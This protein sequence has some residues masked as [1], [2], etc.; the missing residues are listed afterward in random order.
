MDKRW[1][2][3]PERRVVRSHPGTIELAIR[4]DRRHQHPVE[5][6]QQPEDES[7]ER[8]I[9]V[10]P[11]AP[12]CPFDHSSVHL[13]STDVEKLHHHN[14]EQEREHGERNGCALTQQTGTD[15]NLI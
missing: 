8:N 15:A 3:G 5:W 14:D 13:N 12:L 9:K 7:A 1:M 10:N 4:S 2:R 11:A 6:K